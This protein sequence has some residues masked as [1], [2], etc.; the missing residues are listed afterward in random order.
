[1]E[2]IQTEQEIKFLLKSDF[3]FVNSERIRSLMDKQLSETE[4]GKVIV[5]DLSTTQNLDAS[6]I[7]LVLGLAQS[8]KEKE[9][10]LSVKIADPFQKTFQFL[11]LDSVLLLQE[12]VV[13]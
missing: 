10:S 13:S 9:C 7:Q 4:K 6:G 5:L 2:I 12:R 1:M 3:V 11:K 8:C